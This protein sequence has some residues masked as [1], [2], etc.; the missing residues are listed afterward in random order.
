MSTVDRLEDDDR[1]DILVVDDD[2]ANLIAVEVALGDLG[3]SLVKVGSGS[4]ALRQLLTQQFALVLLDVH[5][6]DMNGYETARLIRARP[7]TRHLPIIFITAS[8]PDSAE[9]L[10]GYALGAVDFLFKPI[11][12]EVLRA[13]ASVFVELSRRASEVARQGAMLRE[14]ER[15]EHARQ[16]ETE[17][18]RWESEALRRRMEQERRDA[19]ELSRKAEELARTVA[20]RER[21]EA[22]LKR[23]NERLADAD[24]RKDEFLAML[25]HELRNPLAPVINGLA[26]LREATLQD[27]ASRQVRDAM[28]RQMGHLRRLVDDLLDVSRITSGKIELRLDSIA[29][30][31][32]VEQAIAM[33]RPL[34]EARRHSLTVE[35]A[36]VPI[37]IRAD[38]VRVTQV[39]ANLLNNAARYT[40]DGG[41][42]EVAWSIEDEEAVISVTDDG[43]GIPANRIPSIFDMFVRDSNVG[44]GLGL[45][46][47]LVERIVELH[48][49]RVHVHSDG[50][51]QGSRFEVRLPS[52]IIVEGVGSIDEVSESPAEIRA[53]TLG[54]DIV[55]IEDNADI[56]STVL[57]L[58]EHW[59]H[60][61]VAADD[62]AQ[63]VDLV[64]ATRPD[65]A[66][67]DIGLPVLDGYAVSHRIR[68]EL[69]DA[70]P[71]MIA[72]TGFGRRS[73]RRRSLI[74]GFDAHL[75]K[76][77]DPGQ[78]RD[79]L[80]EHRRDQPGAHHADSVRESHH[81]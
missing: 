45:G 3:R 65:V 21:A 81:L 25:A 76:P 51:G 11:V 69:G 55:V 9:I 64:L 80:A 52:A 1:G 41:H 47:T 53:E 56:R 42:I 10:Q 31:D 7:T 32:V 75:V 79:L 36:S 23:I 50:P 74:A 17:R 67:V 14:H 60:R 37:V 28:E 61:V 13:K 29:L 73:D 27:P 44:G 48:R 71:R 26:V 15:R 2:P 66:I 70:R 43:R 20:E 30:S 22:E 54:L 35:P 63:G 78:L 4:A 34:V 38:A 46:L 58:L 6:P 39:V 33:S 77:V 5:M 40:D 59:G 68:A 8:R 18:H 72:M 19:S 12:P 24:R 16:L 62:G 49:G 57:L